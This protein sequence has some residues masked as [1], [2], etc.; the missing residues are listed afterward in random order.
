MQ[1]IQTDSYKDSSKSSTF[2]HIRFLTNKKRGDKMKQQKWIT[3]EKCGQIKMPYKSC[4]M[5]EIIG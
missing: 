4:G 1:S 2:L 5:C 3:C